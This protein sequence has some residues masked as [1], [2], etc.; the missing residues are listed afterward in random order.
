M[1]NERV[2][3][4]GRCFATQTRGRV[5]RPILPRIKRGEITTRGFA[6]GLNTADPCVQSLLLMNAQVTQGAT[7][8]RGEGDEGQRFVVSGGQLRCDDCGLDE[9]DAAGE[10]KQTPELIADGGAGERVKV[11]AAD[12]NLDPRVQLAEKKE[13]RARSMRS[14]SASF[15]FVLSVKPRKVMSAF[16]SSRDVSAWTSRRMAHSARRRFRAATSPPPVPEARYR[17]S[18]SIGMSAPSAQLNRK[19]RA[20]LSGRSRH[21]NLGEQKRAHPNAQRRRMP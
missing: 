2:N 16:R 13:P 15:A 14:I 8:L 20:G 4:T 17:A 10:F 5:N 1:R 19:P 12:Q 18:R 6:S 3:Q 7:V 11:R 21:R 9:I